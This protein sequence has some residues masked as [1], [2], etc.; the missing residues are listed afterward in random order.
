MYA[1]V[2]IGVPVEK[3]FYYAFPKE[4]A[5]EVIPGKRVI[6]P[7]SGRKLIGYVVGLSRERPNYPLKEITEVVDLLPLF[8]GE[9]LKL[10]KWVSDYYCS[11]WGEALRAAFPPAVRAK[12]KWN[13]PQVKAE[14]SQLSQPKANQPGLPSPSLFSEPEL[15]KCPR[16]ERLKFYSTSVSQTLESGR[17]A[18]ILVPDISRSKNIF[19]AMKSQF[20]GRVSLLTGRLSPEERYREWMRM[21]M[22]VVK[23]VIGTRSAVFAPVADPGLVIVDEENDSLYKEKRTPR[24]NA[25]EVA[26]ERARL[27]GA[28]VILG[29]EAPS[30]ESYFQVEGGKYKLLEIAPG[31]ERKELPKVEIADL[32]REPI[33]RRV[34][35]H[36]LCQEIEERLKIGE[37][38]LLISRRAG[39]HRLID[40]VG[41]LF[42]SARLGRI[43]SKAAYGETIS[44]FLRGKIDILI[45]TEALLEELGVGRASLIGIISADAILSIGDFRAAEKTFQFLTRVLN[46]LS[47]NSKVIIQTFNPDHYSILNA[48]RG[49]YLEFYR[50]ELK[51]RR[52]LNYPPFTSLVNITVKEVQGSG[53]QGSEL[54]NDEGKDDEALKRLIAVLEANRQEGVEILVPTPSLRKAPVQRCQ[55]VVKGKNLDT[56]RETIRKELIAWDKARVSVDVDPL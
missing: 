10:T 19:T 17:G 4:M 52:Q 18:L 33:Q 31:E 11:T 41:R 50:E 45:G 1:E 22:G 28:R 20:G 44:F 37:Q 29:A 26:L 16:Q 21:K 46:S 34:L 9:M 39:M 23:V 12:K 43:D 48:S 15:L 7:F 14:S 30:L 35:S 36:K 49:N 42:P 47:G 53:V 38:I 13:L 27:C 54:E 56:M 8:N 6:V 51:F 24:Y 25:R 40:K 5:H 3:A 2:V 32:C 55:I